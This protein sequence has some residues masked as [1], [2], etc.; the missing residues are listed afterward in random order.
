MRVLVI[1]QIHLWS[2]WIYFDYVNKTNV[3]SVLCSVAQIKQVQ[4]IFAAD[5][6]LGSPN[7][8]HWKANRGR[9]GSTLCVSLQCSLR[10]DFWHQPLNFIP[11]PLG[12]FIITPQNSFLMPLKCTRAGIVHHPSF[13]VHFLSFATFSGIYVFF[14]TP[15]GVFPG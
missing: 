10:V 13:K 6:L 2:K 14:Y 1:Q 4:C 11:L 12:F 5:I 3:D 9:A 7:K 8:W 15:W